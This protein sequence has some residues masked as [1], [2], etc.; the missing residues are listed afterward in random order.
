MLDISP[1][2]VESHM[3]SVFEKLGVSSRSELA[4]LIFG[5]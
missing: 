3:K 5:G 1:Y 4:S 2:T